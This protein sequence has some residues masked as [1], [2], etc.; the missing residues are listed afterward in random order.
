MGKKTPGE[1]YQMV[2]FLFFKNSYVLILKIRYK[3]VN[4]GSIG[5]GQKIRELPLLKLNT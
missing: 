1:H 2:P 3:C 5:E 4:G